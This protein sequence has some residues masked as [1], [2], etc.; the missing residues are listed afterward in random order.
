MPLEPRLTAHCNCLGPT[1]GPTRDPVL[2]PVLAAP[3]PSSRSERG[4]G[5]GPDDDRCARCQHGHGSHD[6]GP[7]HS[8]AGAR[9]AVLISS[10]R[11]NKELL[12]RST[13]VN[14][15]A[16]AMRCAVRQVASF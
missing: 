8:A 11:R 3:K 5:E 12:A 4:A 16:E 9:Q 14:R 10:D 15:I 13:K 7:E 6:A 1:R 2:R